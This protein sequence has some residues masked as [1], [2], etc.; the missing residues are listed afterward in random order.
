MTVL[1]SAALPPPRELHTQWR[2][3]RVQQH[4]VRRAMPCRHRMM[5]LLLQDA[6]EAFMQQNCMVMRT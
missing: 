2:R 1:S 4:A 5:L 3:Q 6:R